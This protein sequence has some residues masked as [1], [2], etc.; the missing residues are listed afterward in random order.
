LSN[1][2]SFKSDKRLGGQRNDYY[3]QPETSEN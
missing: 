2:L 3:T 1:A